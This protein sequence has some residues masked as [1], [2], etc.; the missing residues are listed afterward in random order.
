MLYEVLSC[1]KPG[2]VLPKAQLN[3]RGSLCRLEAQFLSG[4]WILF[5]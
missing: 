5:F 3:L 2:M 4:F 1:W